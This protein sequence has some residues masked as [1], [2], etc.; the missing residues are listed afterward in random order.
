[1][2]QRSN[3]GGGA[4]RRRRR[5]SRALGALIALGAFATPGLSLGAEPA[6]SADDLALRIGREKY[7]R[8]C[9]ACHGPKAEGDGI[10]AHLFDSKPRNLTLLARENGG[11][12][13]TKLLISVVKGKAQIDAHG[14]REMPVWGDIAGRAA[15]ESMV[16]EGAANAELLTIARYL[17]SIQKR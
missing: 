8:H 3:G 6:A 4:R 12:F 1:M 2:E 16:A 17:E 11:K 9:A 7:L 14:S 5:T 15:A 10:A 13:P